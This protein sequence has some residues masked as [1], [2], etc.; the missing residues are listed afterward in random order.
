MIATLL[1]QKQTGNASESGFKPSVWS[2]VVTAVGE[3]ATED[4]GKAIAQC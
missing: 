4:V 2:L 3:A 1:S